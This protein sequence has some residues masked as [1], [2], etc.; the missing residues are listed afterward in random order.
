MLDVRRMRVLR[1]VASKGSFSAAAEALAYTQSAVSQQIAAL[2]RE[3]GTTLVERSSRGVRLTD[4]GRVLVEHAD[5][6]LA[7]LADAEAELEA[8]AGLRGGHLRMASFPS[9]GATIMPEAIARFRAR[10]PAIELTLEPCEPDD[11]LPRLRV[12]EF[13]I[14]LDIVARQRPVDDGIDR[15]HLLEDPMYIALPGSH[16]LAH[17]RQLRLEDL[18][19]ESWIV[20]TPGACPDSSIFLRA[21]ERAGFDPDIVFTSDDYPAIQGF[22]AAGVGASFIPDLALIT[23]RE[24]IVVRSLGPR[25]PSRH[26]M[27]ATLRDSFMSPAKRAMLDLLV[28]VGGEFAGNRRRLAVAV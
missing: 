7:R 17:K 24:D 13:D 5:V 1:E 3:A 23:V 28:E 20:G 16:S 11:A 2:E 4:A 8:I 14:V 6:I 26:I 27:A 19:D 21:C 9:A 12:G 22:V 15:I 25:A 18:S 10:Y